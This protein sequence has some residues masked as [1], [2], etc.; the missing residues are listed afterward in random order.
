MQINGF[1]SVKK[2]F[3]Q[4]LI[5]EEKYKNFFNKKI[6]TELTM[7]LWEWERKRKE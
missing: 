1:S 3:R 7:V 6:K 4:L 5:I 2:S